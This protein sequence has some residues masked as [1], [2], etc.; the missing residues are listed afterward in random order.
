MTVLKRCA[1][2]APVILSGVLAFSACASH[3]HTYGHSRR[4]VYVEAGPPDPVVEVVTV[5]PGAGYCWIPGHHRWDGRSY[6]WIAGRWQLAPRGRTAW[7]T[8]RWESSPRGWFWMEGR[9]N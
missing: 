1:L 9:W 7:V 2:V 8:G 6:L 4:V 3:H 5:S